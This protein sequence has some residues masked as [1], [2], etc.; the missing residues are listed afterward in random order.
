M[1]DL[2]DTIMASVL[3]GPTKAPGTYI[4]VP[5]PHDMLPSLDATPGAKLD[6]LSEPSVRVLALTQFDILS[7][8]YA[9]TSGINW[10]I[11][12]NTNWMSG[13]DP[14]TDSWYGITCNSDGEVI[15]LSLISGGLDGS[16][17]TELGLLTSLTRIELQDNALSKT[18][19]TQLGMMTDLISTFRM[20][21]NSFTGTLPSELGLFSLLVYAF[22]VS[23]LTRT[24]IT[25]TIP[26]Q[27]GGLTALTQ[28]FNIRFNAFTGYI[29]S[30]LGLLTALTS[31][32]YLYSTFITGTI[33]SQVGMMTKLNVGFQVRHVDL[34]SYLF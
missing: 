10:L 4:L 11:A 17:P 28:L 21:A 9:S 24:S 20:F 2:H 32:F 7:K 31:N 34:F 19:P 14:C 30:E 1:S 13:S 22:D 18:I 27:L 26:C 16:L 23:D 12:K 5:P 25:G 33:P 3:P 6:V 29:P 15:Y 8:L